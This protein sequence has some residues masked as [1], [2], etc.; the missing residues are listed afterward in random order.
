[1]IKGWYSVELPEDE[2]N[3][4]KDYLRKARIYFEP[5]EVD[6]LVHFEC[7]MT[8]EE[9][10]FVNDFLYNVVTRGAVSNCF[11]NKYGLK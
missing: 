11:A 10:G 7:L 5:S 3:V 4:L 9:R 6:N 8:T 1:M 2:A